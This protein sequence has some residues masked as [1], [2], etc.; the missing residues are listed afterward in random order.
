MQ[1]FSFNSDVK[2]FGQQVC[3]ASN[4]FGDQR[5]EVRLHVNTYLSVHIHPQVQIVNSGGNA[6]FNC[7]ITGTGVEQIEWYHNGVAISG[8]SEQQHQRDIKGSRC[9]IYLMYNYS[10]QNLIG[11]SFQ[12]QFLTF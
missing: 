10:I 11:H 9:D 8:S 12:I 3:K 7:S 1:K 5:I 4:Q 6:V 2:P